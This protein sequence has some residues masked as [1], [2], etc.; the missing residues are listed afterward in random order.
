[1]AIS[2][3]KTRINGQE[4]TLTY[5]ESSGAY[6][7]T[8]TAPT[9]TS[10][11]N[12]AG[13]G[14]GV[15]AEAAGKGYYPVEVEV[16]DNAGNVSTADDTHA[17]LGESCQL[18]VLET[19]APVMS[20]GYPTAG[21]KLITAKPEIAFTITDSGSG[22]N[23]ESCKLAID[24]GEE[25]AVTATGSGSS[26]AGAYTPAEALAD[27]SHTV[28]V[29]GYDFDGNKSNVA[30]VT[31]TVDTVAPEL[32]V[33][34][35]VADLVTN[36]SAGV[37]AGTTS[38]VTSNPV[39][40]T[41]NLNGQDLGAISVV[42]GAFSKNVTYVSGRNTIVVTATDASGKYTTVTRE[43]ILN[44]VAPTIDEITITPNPATSGATYIISVK[45]TDNTP[46]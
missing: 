7:A 38:D 15:G 28:T 18:A 30:T 41:I 32:T 9:E 10:G 39:T 11:S 16:A 12:N 27:G 35:P 17:T 34:T 5:N 26:F 3:I 40:V 4:Y 21:A 20:I 13:L 33:T 1:M 14:P 6:E 19:V 31:F 42:D 29:Y 22:V 8:I 25:I 44:T 37:I 24:G 43:V 23:P 45:V 36:M 46:V 2:Y